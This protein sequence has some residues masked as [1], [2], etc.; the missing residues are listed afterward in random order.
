VGPDVSQTVKERLFVAPSH[1]KCLSA[2]VVSFWQQ[3]IITGMI[4]QSARN[5][6]S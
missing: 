5:P 2:E 4:R 3:R 1:D 6:P